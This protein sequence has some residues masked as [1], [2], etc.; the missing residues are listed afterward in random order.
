MACQSRVIKYSIILVAGGQ[1]K[2]RERRE[3]I[4]HLRKFPEESIIRSVKPTN[5]NKDVLFEMLKEPRLIK[6]LQ[7]KLWQ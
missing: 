3:N 1:R 7:A 2:G 6:T 5:N 4:T